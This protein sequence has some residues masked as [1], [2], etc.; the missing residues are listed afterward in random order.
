ML[1]QASK[2]T[3]LTM[4]DVEGLFAR[5]LYRYSTADSTGREA[6][7]KRNIRKQGSAKSNPAIPDFD[8]PDTRYLHIP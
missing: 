6:A 2:P 1:A 4:S 3:A 8:N 5:A 7:N